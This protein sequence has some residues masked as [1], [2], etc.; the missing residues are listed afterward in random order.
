MLRGGVSNVW[1]VGQLESELTISPAMAVIDDEMIGYVK[2]LKQGVMVND[3][4]LALE[5]TREVGVAGSYLD[6]EHTLL[7]Y[8]DEL[9]MPGIGYRGSREDWVAAG[10]K[11]MAERAEEVAGKLMAEEVDSGLDEEQLAEL[12]RLAGEFV[13]G[14]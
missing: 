6:H 1:G 3:K 14:L 8:R 4:S 13:E 5:V 7:N 2:R 12:D 9:Y 10:G 11:T